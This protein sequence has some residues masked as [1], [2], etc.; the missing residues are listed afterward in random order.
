MFNL[1][2]CQS[3]FKCLYVFYENDNDFC[4][5]Y[6]KLALIAFIKYKNS[7]AAVW[8]F[9]TVLHTMKIALQWTFKWLKIVF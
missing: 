4:F 1:C 6:I 5:K 2:L 3:I 7:N 8:Y 9:A